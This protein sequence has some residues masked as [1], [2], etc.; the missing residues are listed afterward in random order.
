MAAR[1]PAGRVGS[2]IAERDASEKRHRGEARVGGR[3]RARTTGTPDGG[4]CRGQVAAA[5]CTGGVDF[6]SVSALTR[7]SGTTPKSQQLSPIY[8]AALRGAAG[9][10][11]A[12]SRVRGRRVLAS[13]I[14]IATSV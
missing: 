5:T 3:G 13:Q 4:S 2:L 7:G 12:S 8:A 14:S 9:V 1:R 6:A 10:G 11:R